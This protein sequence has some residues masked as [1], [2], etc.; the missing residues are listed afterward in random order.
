MSAFS[1]TWFSFSLLSITALALAEL[2]QQKILHRQAKFDERTSAVLTVGVQ[3]PLILS[4]IFLS[5]QVNA[6]LPAL[7][8]KSFVFICFLALIGSFANIFYFKSLNV[9]NISI[10]TI[11]I[12]LSVV[13]STILGII[14]F[15]ESQ[16]LVK[17]LG[18]GLVL[19]AIVA[20]NWKNV[21]IEKYH[22]YGLATGAM[23]GLS[24]TLDKY[25]SLNMNTLVFMFLL[26]S[27]STIFMAIENPKKIYNSVI[28]AS[29]KEY[30]P[31]LLSGLGYF[32]F[33][34]FTLTAYKLG[35][36]VGIIDA[37]NNSQT[38]IIILVEYFIFKQTQ[39]VAK[40]LLTAIIAIIGIFILGM[41]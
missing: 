11:F 34:F 21:Q 19:T 1:M 2:S 4:L 35:G 36:E 5:G 38:F 40:K 39:G 24:Y 9:K 8:N 10:S 30:I 13:V 31:I 41:V 7:L 26:W 17:F 28:S 20:L 6:I 27:M 3:I 14:V 32:F 15:Q 16:S 33:N 29:S 37:I 18:I 25:I 22:Y 23:Y 12:S